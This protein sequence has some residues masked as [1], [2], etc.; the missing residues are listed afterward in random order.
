MAPGARRITSALFGRLAALVHGNVSKDRLARPT[1]YIK[2]HQRWP[3]VHRRNMSPTP[4]AKQKQR[5]PN[6]GAAT[7]QHHPGTTLNTPA[8][9]G[10][11]QCAYWRHGRQTARGLSPIQQ[12]AAS[13]W[14]RGWGAGVATC[15]AA[16]A[17]HAASMHN[18]EVAAQA[19]LLMAAFCAQ[20][21][22][23][24]S[25]LGLTAVWFDG[26]S[27]RRAAPDY[28]P[29]ILV[30]EGCAD[31]W[32]NPELDRWRKWLTTRAIWPTT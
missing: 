16:A 13:F 3:Q 21:E 8:R 11:R 15:S 30:V 26:R 10:D 4:R 25:E 9:D 18:Q 20:R 1:P 28:A 6:A 29:A 19:P 17:R 24:A 5:N 12:A 27:A 23:A 22:R 31:A 7:T 14:R 32:S 2:K